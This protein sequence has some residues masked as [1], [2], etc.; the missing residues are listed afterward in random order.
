MQIM[1]TLFLIYANFSKLEKT[2]LACITY[3]A[4]VHVSTQ[5]KGIRTVLLVGAVVVLILDIY[6]YIGF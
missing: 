1:K 3:Y 5:E 2:L 4:G 6:L